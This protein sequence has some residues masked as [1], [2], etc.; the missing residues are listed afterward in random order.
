MW[1]ISYEEYMLFHEM[2]TMG[3]GSRD[4]YGFG[5][6]G[7]VY[8]GTYLFAAGEALYVA[9]EGKIRMLPKALIGGFMASDEVADEVEFELAG[10]DLLN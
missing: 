1:G 4:F 3:V 10:D 9:S 6:N 8:A 5:D 7:R 2:S